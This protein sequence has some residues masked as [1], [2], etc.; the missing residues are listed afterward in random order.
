MSEQAICSAIAGRR[1]LQF[2]YTGDK[3]PGVR[4]AEPYQLGYTKKENL[5]LSAYYL[6]G[7]SESSTGPGWKLYRVEEMSQIVAL[8]T[9]FSGQRPE[10]RPGTNKVLHRIVCEL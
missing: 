6:S 3:V 2:Y 1:V 4:V 9:Q 5:A 7:A 10:Y 8:P